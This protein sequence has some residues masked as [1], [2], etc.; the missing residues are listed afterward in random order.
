MTGKLLSTYSRVC[1]PV[2][3]LVISVR[4]P[5]VDAV[6]FGDCSKLLRWQLTVFSFPRPT[7]SDTLSHCPARPDYDLT[8]RF[9]FEDGSDDRSKKIATCANEIYSLSSPVHSELCSSPRA[10]GTPSAYYQAFPTPPYFVL[11]ASAPTSRTWRRLYNEEFRCGEIDWRT[12]TVYRR[13]Q[14]RR[15]S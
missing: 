15:L 12:D 9:L 2:E 11:R 7:T 14:T 13:K 5:C 1:S 8:T 4:T 6:L 10:N 3:R